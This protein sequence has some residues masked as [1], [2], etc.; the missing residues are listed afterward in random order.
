MQVI[1]N[2]HLIK[3]EAN[4]PVCA[5][6]LNSGMKYTSNKKSEKKGRTR[7]KY[8]TSKN[9]KTSSA[10]RSLSKNITSPYNKATGSKERNQGKQSSATQTAREMNRTARKEKLTAKKESKKPPQSSSKLSSWVEV[11]NNGSTS[12]ISSNLYRNIESRPYPGRNKSSRSN[13]S[14][15]KR[16]H[17]QKHHS[18]TNQPLEKQK[19]VDVT[20]PANFTTQLFT[21]INK[22]HSPK[23]SKSHNHSHSEVQSKAVKRIV[24]P[25]NRYSYKV[26][27]KSSMHIRSNTSANG[28]K[29]KMKI[30]PF[31]DY[32]NLFRSMNNDGATGRVSPNKDGLAF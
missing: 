13:A 3:K 19:T 9:K 14:T 32:T 20:N 4:Y 11:M 17:K 2:K 27:K 12:E 28:Q 30:N 31:L 5:F 10:A 29:I 23:S 24:N 15:K 6:N 7:S 8:S 26:S 25:K 22:I 18:S 1:S 16:V 21:L